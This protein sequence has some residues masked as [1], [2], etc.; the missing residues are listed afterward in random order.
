[1]VED[2][3]DLV[4]KGEGRKDSEAVRANSQTHTDKAISDSITSAETK[5]SW[6]G[7]HSF[8]S[9]SVLT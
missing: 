8:R 4:E 5:A 6:E 1:M 3:A 7:Q 2:E 9:H